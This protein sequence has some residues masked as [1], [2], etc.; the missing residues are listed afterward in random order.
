MTQYPA[1]PAPPSIRIRKDGPYVVTGLPVRRMHAAESADGELIAWITEPDLPAPEVTV[2][3]RC[4]RSAQKPFCDGSHRGQFDGTETAPESAYDERAEDYPGAGIVMRDDRG[5]CA[6]TGFCTTKGTT[7]WK[8]SHL[9]EDPAARAQ[10]VAMV[11]HCPSGALTYRGTGV[12]RDAEPDLPAAVGVIDDG[13][14][15]IT[16]SVPVQLSDGRAAEVRPRMTLC[17]CGGSANKPY[18]DG[19]HATVGFADS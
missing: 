14:L 18:C 17:R 15:W 13:P 10:L 7:A 8:L 4:G 5:L 1:N 11:E 16:G 9:T 12:E 2:L 3:C 19:T 6:H